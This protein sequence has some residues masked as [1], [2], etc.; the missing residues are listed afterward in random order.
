MLTDRDIK[1]EQAID[2]ALSELTRAS[3]KNGKKVAWSRLKRLHR[4]RSSAVIM[5]M[6]SEKGLR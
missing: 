3:T 2:K 1:N 4:K 6:E 5:K